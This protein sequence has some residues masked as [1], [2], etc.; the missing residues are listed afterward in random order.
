ML[1][2]SQNGDHYQLEILQAVETDKGRYVCVAHNKVGTA[3]SGVS[4]VVQAQQ[5]IEFADY[6]SLLKNK[7]VVVF[8]SEL[9]IVIFIYV[10]TYII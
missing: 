5:G 1:Q 3:K 2:M 6:R 8:F 10:Y 4:L 9:L 7:Y